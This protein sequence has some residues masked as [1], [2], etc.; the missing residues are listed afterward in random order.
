M[1]KFKVLDFNCSC[2]YKQ[3]VSEEGTILLEGDFY[4]DKISSQIEGFELGV[5]YATRGNCIFETVE[6][7]AC[8]TCK[9]EGEQNEKDF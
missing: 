9:L 3:L 4:H 5:F 2:E 1:I 8:L 7:G 6:M